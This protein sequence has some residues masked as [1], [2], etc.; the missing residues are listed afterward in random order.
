[1]SQGFVLSL[2]SPICLIFTIQITLLLFSWE[3]VQAY[4]IIK[5][6]IIFQLAQTNPFQKAKSTKKEDNQKSNLPDTAQLLEK[7]QRGILT[8]GDAVIPN[9]GSFYDSYPL[10][11]KAGDSFIIELESQ[12]FDTFLAIMDSE[13]NILQQND[14]VGDRDS[15]SRIRVTLPKDGVY[16]VIVNAYDKKGKG[17]Y[18]LTIRR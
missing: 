4:S 13:G 10:Q 2:V 7:I 12:D 6:D 3:R 17:E 11:A 5:S 1:M 16:S 9:D 8:D 14:D 15:N 18:V